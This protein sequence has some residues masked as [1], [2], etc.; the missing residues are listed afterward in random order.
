MLLIAAM[1]LPAAGNVL[2]IGPGGHAAIEPVH[3][4]SG[5][6]EVQGRT[7]DTDGQFVAAASD[8]C[9]DLPLGILKWKSRPE[10]GQEQFDAGQLDL[11]TPVYLID[12]ASE[13]SSK[14][15]HLSRWHDRDSI[16]ELP[17]MLRSTVLLL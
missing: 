15:A 8:D 11:L 7:T 2:C 13:A 6:D 17:L 5:C 14:P 9:V 1:V 3:P 16:P 4:V 12:L 10:R